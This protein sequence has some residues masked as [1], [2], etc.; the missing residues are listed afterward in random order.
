MAD[1]QNFTTGVA[2]A[3][4]AHLVNRSRQWKSC[5][6]TSASLV[7]YTLIMI[8]QFHNMQMNKT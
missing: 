7:H 8:C 3:K 6:V 1:S 5:H 2:A 4:M